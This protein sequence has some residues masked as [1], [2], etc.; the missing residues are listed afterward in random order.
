[1]DGDVLN[2]SL[3]NL[4]QTPTYLAAF[5]PATNFI[6]LSSGGYSSVLQRCIKNWAKRHKGT[7]C[8]GIFPGNP[9]TLRAQA[10]LGR[11]LFGSFIKV[12]WSNAKYPISNSK[13]WPQ[14]IRRRW[15]SE[16]SVTNALNGFMLTLLSGISYPKPN[17]LSHPKWRRIG[18]QNNS[19]QWYSRTDRRKKNGSSSAHL[20]CQVSITK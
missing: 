8:K 15:S 1:M 17:P 7:Y 12:M 9:G 3:L 14:S 20:G 6:P 4:K 18:A 13:V 16:L 10:V 2:Q 19:C 5:F 11:G